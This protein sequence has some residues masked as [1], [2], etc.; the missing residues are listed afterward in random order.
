[1]TGR[2][3]RHQ[4]R[5]TRLSFHPLP[6]LS[7]AKETYSAAVQG[8]LASVRYQGS[9]QSS[10]SAA[11]N[12]TTEPEPLLTPEPS[13]QPNANAP[14]ASSPLSD[15]P[16]TPEKSDEIREQEE[17]EIVV[18]SSKRRK[19]NAN[20]SAETPTRRP[21]RLHH[22]ETPPTDLSLRSRTKAQNTSRIASSPPLLRAP[23]I[24]SPE[25]SGDEEISIFTKLTSRRKPTRQEG[26]DD[27]FVV[28]DDIEDEPELRP[29]R[30][31][32][33]SRPDRAP[34]D[35][36]VADDDEVEYVS[37]S[38][39]AVQRIEKQKSRKNKRR[40]RSRRE[41]NEL[42]E[43]LEDLVGSGKDDD[44]PDVDAVNTNVRRTR[45]GPVTTER[46]RR[47]EHIETLKRRR[48]GEKIPRVQD[49]DDEQL[50]E[51][52]EQDGA[53][54]NRIGLHTSSPRRALERIEIS[55]NSEDEQPQEAESIE[56]E[57]D[58][59][60]VV[61]DEEEV[62]HGRSPQSGIP[63]AFT[64][65]ASSKP[66]ELFIHV[67]EWLV[68]NKIA[69]AFQRDDELYE[70]SWNKINDQ[71][72]AQAGSRL[73]SS[74]WG[75][76]FKNTI[77][78]RPRMQVS[79]TSGGDDELFLNC[80]AC[81][82]TNHPARYEF[83]FSGHAYHPDTLEPIDEDADESE[84]DKEEDD[85]EDQDDKASYDAAGHLLPRA[86]RTFNLGRFCAANAE[87]GHKLTHWKYH[88]NQA[89]LSYL[90]EQGVLSAES[91]L[92][93]E[94]MSKKKREKQAEEIVDTM[95][96]TGV[97]NEMWRD[98]QND[99]ED[100]RFG[101]EDHVAKGGKRNHKRIGKVRVDRGDGKIEEWSE[102]GKMKM[103]VLSDSDGE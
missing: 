8:R 84:S 49:S 72:K 80:D 25:T 101:M 88:L 16:S 47:R 82:R 12:L 63:L 78:A 21:S 37:S 10:R 28:D 96:A 45:G 97:I 42:E 57:D 3:L 62:Q 31:R 40:E 91:I 33:T 70:L 89:L 5:Q 95:D 100:A 11:R 48:A 51:F 23:S 15:P 53:D 81:N 19:L 98:L 14:R 35:D 46:D 32:R 87:M 92:A 73:I 99:L 83:K 44:V 1:M 66:K 29:N 50:D 74:A 34:K 52:D 69:P 41:Q 59:D 9:R 17:D 27:P 65:F 36:F 24:G 2:S 79:F 76:E 55:S 30:T 26:D 93:R 60:F 85:D 13:S 20:G 58:D 71:I 102:G 94:K 68:K 86:G 103:V 75:E 7:P 43:D 90:D 39:E 61:E 4:K 64:S 22:L 6:D 56:I 77:L 18:S 38:D 67:V 54:I